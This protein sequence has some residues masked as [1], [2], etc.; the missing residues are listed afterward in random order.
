MIAGGVGNVGSTAVKIKR[1]LTH[2]HEEA[3]DYSSRKLM[4][5]SKRNT[6][7]KGPV[8]DRVQVYNKKIGRFV[9]ID[10]KN[11]KILG[12]SRNPYKRVRRK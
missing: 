5:Y 11:S 8:R 7:L 4:D 1:T 10:T 3:I 6:G 12:S 9:K 2:P